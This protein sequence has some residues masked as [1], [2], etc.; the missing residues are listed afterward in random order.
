MSKKWKNDSAT[1]AV[2]RRHFLS[3]SGAALAAA[4]AVPLAAQTQL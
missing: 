2:T 4:T 3:V 1:S